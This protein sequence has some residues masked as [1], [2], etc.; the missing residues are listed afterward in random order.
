ME[1]QSEGGWHN[2]GK[3][4]L[5]LGSTDCQVTGQKVILCRGIEPRP[6]AEIIQE[7]Q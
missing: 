4:S 5:D 3:K 2:K 1:F 6:T 7:E